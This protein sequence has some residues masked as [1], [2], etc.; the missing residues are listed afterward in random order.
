MEIKDRVYGKIDINEP[1]LLTLL[2]SKPLIRLQGIN[3]A[4][5]SQYAIPNKIVSR[6]EHSVGV[7]LLLKILGASTEEQIAGLLGR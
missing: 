6:Y 3:Q 5:A 1:V 7:M 4:G 2:K